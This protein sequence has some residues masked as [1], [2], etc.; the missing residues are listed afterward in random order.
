[1]KR[2]LTIAF[3]ICILPILS[4]QSANKELTQEELLELMDKHRDTVVP[5]PDEH[6]FDGMKM[7][8]ADEV[9]L[10]E[11]RMSAT[12]L[13]GNPITGVITL[14]DEPN[15]K[16]MRAFKNGYHE[17]YNLQRN[18]DRTY[19]INFKKGEKNPILLYQEF[20]G[21]QLIHETQTDIGYYRRYN[22][23]GKLIWDA[24]K[25][26]DGKNIIRGYDK[27]GE[28]TIELNTF[29]HSAICFLK[30]GTQRNATREEA[31]RFLDEQEKEVSKSFPREDMRIEPDY[32]FDFSCK[33]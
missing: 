25:N 14:I 19:L 9:N 12:D 8:N 30:N 32:E 28:K 13:N 33:E 18:D 11:N 15:R 5:L 27:N 1:M 26:D 21:N 6:I 23:A 31:E 29:V 4:A 10:S 2:I 3:L 24:F 17:G 20:W 16:E 22:E 7:Y